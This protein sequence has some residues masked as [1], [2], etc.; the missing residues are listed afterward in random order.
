M[1]T[2][3]KTSRLEK[4]GTPIPNE[5]REFIIERAGGKCEYCGK[6]GQEI[7]HILYRSRGGDNNKNNLILL[8]RV[9]HGTVSILKKIALNPFNY[10]GI[11]KW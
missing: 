10:I 6:R 9:C 7:H 5:T 2:F 1:K 8:C 4:K 11:Y 3:F